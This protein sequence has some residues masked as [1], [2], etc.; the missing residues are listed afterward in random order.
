MNQALF[1][2]LL[3]A[4]ALSSSLAQSLPPA[5]PEIGPGNRVTFRIQ[6]SKAAEVSLKGQWSRQAIAMVRGEGGWWSISVD[7]V[8]AGIWE[9]HF[10]IDGLSVLDGL[11]PAFKPQRKPQSSILHLPASPPSPW[12]WQDV[13]HGA[14]H[15][16][17][18]ASKVLGRQREL[19]VYTPPGYERSGGQTYPMLVLQHGSGDN[20][21]TWVDHGKAGWI[22]DTLIAQGE[23]VPVVIVMLDGHPNGMVSRDDAGGRA[24]AMTAFQHE[25]FEDALPL[26]EANYRV[27]K[28]AGRRA[29]A[30]LSM[31]GGQSLTTGLGHLAQFGWIGA[32]S[33]GPPSQD[34]LEGT[35][36]QADKVNKSLRLLWI[37]VGKDDFL[38]QRNEEMIAALEKAGIR[39]EWHLTEGDHSWPVWR[40]Y[41]VE[42]APRLFQA[43]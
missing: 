28:E 14:V 22:L 40:R 2:C 42:F 23:A 39:H 3:S 32:F 43:H 16:H 37:A 35:L 10:A 20:Q 13:P 31:G 34:V 9:Y 25:L 7:A 6:A 17:D 21:R 26:V 27:A 15:H 1:C 41:L 30:G 5:S 12:D 8:P 19:L 36:K 4:A 24:A 29:I 33:A 11:N 38:R 18:Y